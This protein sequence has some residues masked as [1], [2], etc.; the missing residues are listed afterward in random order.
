MHGVFRRVINAI[1]IGTVR[2]THPYLPAIFELPYRDLPDSCGIVRVGGAAVG[3]NVTV[4]AIR[5]SGIP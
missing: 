5:V 2:D 1:V 4:R 3:P